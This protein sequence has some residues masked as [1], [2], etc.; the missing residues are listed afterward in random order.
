MTGPEN[1]PFTSSF[2][3]ISPGSDTEFGPEPWT[4]ADGYDRDRDDIFNFRL[5]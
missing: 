4:S 2:A 1:Q 3:L 5:P